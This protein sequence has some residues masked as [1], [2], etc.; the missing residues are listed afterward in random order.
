MKQLFTKKSLWLVSFTS[1]YLVIQMT[2]LYLNKL[3]IA[4]SSISKTINLINLFVV[5]ILLCLTIGN[6]IKFAYHADM[7][8][9]HKASV[10]TIA[11]TRTLFNFVKSVAALFPI[12]LTKGLGL[13][14]L[15][16]DLS[17]EANLSFYT[18]LLI[19]ILI[20]LI[21]ISTLIFGYILVT[22]FYNG[23]Y[24]EEDENQISIF[25]WL[26]TYRPKTKSEHKSA[27]EKANNITFIIRIIILLAY[28]KKTVEL[29]FKVRLT[30][31]K[32]L[33]KKKVSPHSSLT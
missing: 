18:Q 31:W 23:D 27:T 30:K 24:L 1:I 21:L 9:N 33:T 8:I 2:L 20:L 13:Y 22:Y 6:F 28:L 11:K 17:S 15:L 16:E 4:D 3:V 5:V 12:L 10:K 26:K 7:I 25:E 29:V 32:V 14:L 19:L